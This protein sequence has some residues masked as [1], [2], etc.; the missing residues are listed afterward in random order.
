[1]VK[2]ASLLKPSPTE[3]EIL[4][5]LWKRGPST[6]REVHEEL[7]ERRDAGYYTYL[8]LLQI[9]DQKGLAR[10]DKSQR[11]HIY[12]A[13]ISEET[14]EHHLVRD[15]LERCFE[16]SAQRLIMRALETKRF[17]RDELE[18]IRGLMDSMEGGE[19]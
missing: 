9:M 11:A 5:V 19:P 6:V 17:S 18:E 14:T 13:A 4:R 10:R 15:M 2:D 16:G 12:E 8:K 7:K 3:L 1:M